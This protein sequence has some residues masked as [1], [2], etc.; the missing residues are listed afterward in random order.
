[1][2]TKRKAP[3]KK[4][5]VIGLGNMGRGIAKNLIKAGNDVF[6]RDVA[7]AARQ[8]YAESATISE[9]A[10]LL[11]A[12]YRGRRTARHRPGLPVHEGKPGHV[13]DRDNL[14]DAG[15]IA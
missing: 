1:M 9:P 14:N 12:R 7:E 6:V 8:A 3:R 2:T 13:L 11:G 15:R 5:G 10:G 4:I